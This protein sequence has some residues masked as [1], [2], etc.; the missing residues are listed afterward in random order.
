MGRD[1][2]RDLQSSPSSGGGRLGPASEWQR[3][4]G[5][6][7]ARLTTAAA[8][9]Q[10]RGCSVTGT[11]VHTDFNFPNIQETNHNLTAKL[12]HVGCLV[13]LYCLW[14]LRAQPVL[15]CSVPFKPLDT[16]FP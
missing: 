11:Y 12:G 16:S 2:E 8:R 4:S 9:P 5:V 13:V 3:A 15:F 1:V 14:V 6:V 10:T 7:L